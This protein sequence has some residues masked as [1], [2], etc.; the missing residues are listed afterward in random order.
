LFNG[1]C[2][3]Q[4]Y[5]DKLR[6]SDRSRKSILDEDAG[7]LRRDEEAKNSIF[8]TWQISFEHVHKF[9]PSTAELL[10]LMSFCDRQAI[11]EAL[12]RR[13]SSNEVVGVKEA[14]RGFDGGLGNSSSD[15]SDSDAV[16]VVEDKKDELNDA[17]DKDIRMLEG[18]SFV[19]LTTDTSTFE[20]H[21]LV[22]VATRKRLRSRDQLE[23]WKER[24]IDNL[25]GLFPPGR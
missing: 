16:S 25:C 20:M 22:Q 2:S 7:D 24:C 8:L 15:S 19:S 17:F 18:Y 9:R 5:I 13:R 3:T 6:K 23:Q 21:R 11:P 4:K 12:V 1:R 14:S 10:S